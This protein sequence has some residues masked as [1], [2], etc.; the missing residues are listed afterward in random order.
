MKLYLSSYGLGEHPE[1]LK[2]LVGENKTAAVIVNAQDLATEEKRQDRLERAEQEMASLGFQ[3]EELDLRSYFGRPEELADDL[4]RYGL[5][6][7][8]GGNVFVLRRAMRQSG[9]D[10]CIKELVE[11]EKL[12]YAGF[13]AGS[14]V[15]APD[16][17]GIELVDDAENVPAGYDSEITWEGLNL[18]DFAIAPHYRS[19]HYESEAIERTVEYFKVHDIQHEALRDGQAIVVNGH[20][21]EIVG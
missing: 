5:L 3:P 12:V 1:K 18:I 10:L 7:I 4:R 21:K 8:R 13:S 6:W 20:Q 14:C 15:A 11:S 9:F 2:E 17:R 19:D 16:L